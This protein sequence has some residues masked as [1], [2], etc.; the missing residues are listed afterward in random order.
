VMNSMMNAGMGLPMMGSMLFG[1]TLW[2]LLLAVLI[3]ALLPWLNRPWGKPTM[4]RTFP[5]PKEPT[6]QEILEQRY[7]GGE[8]D[9]ATGEQMREPFQKDLRPINRQIR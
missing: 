1:I 6:A 4:Q 7:T 5:S 8:I 9:H 2:I 3:W